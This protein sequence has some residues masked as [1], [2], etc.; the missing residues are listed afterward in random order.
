MPS[1]R[2]M[3]LTVRANRPA[4][5]AWRAAIEYL[6]FGVVNWSEK[7]QP[8]V[9]VEVIMD[10]VDDAPPLLFSS[11]AATLAALYML[12]YGKHRDIVAAKM[13]ELRLTK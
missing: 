6:A 9:I 4:Y 5:D 10:E 8:D 7:I 3:L 12:G 11:R 13:V 2:E 1:V